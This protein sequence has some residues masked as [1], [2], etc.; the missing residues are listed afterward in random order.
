MLALAA[1]ICTSTYV[2]KPQP[3][4]TGGGESWAFSAKATTLPILHCCCH[5]LLAENGG[6]VL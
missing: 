6:E 4:E 5:H 3:L 2:A 1:D